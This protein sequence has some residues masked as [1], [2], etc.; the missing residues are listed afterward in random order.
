MNFI[1]EACALNNSDDIWYTCISVQDGVWSIRM[2]A[3]SCCPFELSPL[4]EF[5]RRGGLVCS[6][7]LIPYEIF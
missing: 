5:Y 7:T 6:I 3:P 2:V 1:G 4:N